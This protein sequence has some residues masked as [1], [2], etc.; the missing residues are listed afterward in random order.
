[1]TPH[2]LTPIDGPAEVIMVF[3]RDG[4]GARVYREAGRPPT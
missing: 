4:H 2:A 3:N 1:M